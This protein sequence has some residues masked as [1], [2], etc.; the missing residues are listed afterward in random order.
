MIDMTT[1]VPIHS[2]VAPGPGGEPTE[3]SSTVDVAKDQAAS[4][5]H[6][7]AD[8]GRHVAGVAKDQAQSVVAVVAE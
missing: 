2:G 6:G 8:T 1:N 3:A 4:V 7:A 5:G